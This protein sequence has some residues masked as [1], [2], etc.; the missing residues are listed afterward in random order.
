VRWSRFPCQTRPIGEQRAQHAEVGPPGARAPLISSLVS[1]VASSSS[2]SRL[3][4]GCDPP[5]IDEKCGSYRGADTLSV[6]TGEHVDG[7]ATFL[8]SRRA[9]LTASSTPNPAFASV[10]ERATGE[11]LFGRAT[12]RG[13]ARK[14]SEWISESALRAAAYGC[15]AGSRSA[16][17]SS[18]R[19]TLSEVELQEALPAARRVRRSRA[20]RERDPL[21]GG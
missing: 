21:V 10:A 13:T 16:R 8:A 4:C 5:N 14:I 18:R 17:E 1:A 11:R 6:V 20:N 15:R 3:R 19:G 12:P 9:N 2:V 7:I